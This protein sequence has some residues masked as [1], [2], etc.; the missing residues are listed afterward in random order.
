MG[1]IWCR[2]CLLKHDTGGKTEG[3]IE[4]RGRRGGKRQQQLDDLKEMR[5]CWNLEQKALDHTV[6]R[7]GFERSYGCASD[8][9]LNE[10]MNE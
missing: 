8:R 9:L 10:S 7:T 3:R 1:H 2:N 5:G 4:M 6:L